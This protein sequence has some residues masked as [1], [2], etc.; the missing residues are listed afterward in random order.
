MKRGS[1]AARRQVGWWCLRGGGPTR[2][3]PPQPDAAVPS[4]AAAPVKLS[5]LEKALAEVEKFIQDAGPESQR[6][7]RDALIYT[8]EHTGKVQIRREP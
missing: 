2:A 8:V 6:I 4:I 5:D 3:P 1:Q 7:D